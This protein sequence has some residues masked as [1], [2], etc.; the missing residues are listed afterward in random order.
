MPPGRYSTGLGDLEVLDSGK[1]VLAGQRDILAGASQPIHVCVANVMRF[2]GVSLQTAVEMASTSPLR[3]IGE[4]ERGLE[5]GEAA[6]LVLFDLPKDTVSPLNI[7]MTV[8]GGEVV[9]QG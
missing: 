4:S 2:A 1:L 5:V 8:N 3:L 7:R 6:N 9:Y